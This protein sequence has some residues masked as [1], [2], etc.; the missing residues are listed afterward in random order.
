MPN[1]YGIT[2]NMGRF[3]SNKRIT[4]LMGKQQAS[5][6]VTRSRI[7]SKDFGV[8]GEWSSFTNLQDLKRRKKSRMNHLKNNDMFLMSA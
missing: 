4:K 6:P 7:N 8:D 2:S 1:S 3:K 5:G